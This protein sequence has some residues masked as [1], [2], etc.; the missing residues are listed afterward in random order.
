M[1]SGVGSDYARE[2]IALIQSMMKVA[3]GMAKAAGIAAM[4]FGRDQAQRS[5]GPG[6][7]N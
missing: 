4:T 3:A 7:A 6:R 5:A 1:I 2:L